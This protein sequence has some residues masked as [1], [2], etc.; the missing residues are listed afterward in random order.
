MDKRS[1]G[2]DELSTS[3]RERDE[4]RYWQPFNGKTT[5]HPCG[6]IRNSV[7]GHRITILI[8]HGLEQLILQHRIYIIT[9]TQGEVIFGHA[10]AFDF[11]KHIR[12]S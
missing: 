5:E 7:L 12:N 8:S 1:P 3:R 11:R 10:D 6:V 9:T 2:K 4:V